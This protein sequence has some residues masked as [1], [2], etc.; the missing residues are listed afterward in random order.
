MKKIYV[1]AIHG[2]GGG[3]WEF[4]L[5]WKNIIEGG[6]ENIKLIAI[7]LEPFEGSYEKTTFEHYLQQI[8]DVII[9]LTIQ[10][11]S[12]NFILMGASMGGMLVLKSYEILQYKYSINISAII[13]ICTTIPLKIKLQYI[14]LILNSDENGYIKKQTNM[15]YPPMIKWS[16]GIFQ[17][18][19]DTLYDS[20]YDTQS[21]A[22]QHWRDE[23]GNVLNY[24]SNGISLFY[25]HNTITTTTTTTINITNDNNDNNHNDNNVSTTTTNNIINSN[26]ENNTIFPPTLMVIP[27]G[28]TTIPPIEQKALGNQLFKYINYS[29]IIYLIII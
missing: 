8:T 16:N 19:I 12:A 11:K 4:D 1:I 13:L 22:H 21:Y 9:N 7:H 23:S 17:D 10:N 6:S 25:L 15:K 2:A 18:T 29:I 14:N 20:N 5:Y 24:I 28:D 27:L 3:S 26:N